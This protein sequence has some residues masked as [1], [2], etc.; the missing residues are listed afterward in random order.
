MHLLGA[1]RVIATDI[2]R[3]V[4]LNALHRSLH[5]ATGSIVRDILSP[6]EDHSI[7]RERLQRLLSIPTLTLDVLS[8][9]CGIEYVAPV[10]LLH[11]PIETQTDFVFSNAVLDIV[12]AEE[13]LPLLN[14]LGR[15]LSS[16]G[17][18]I[19][20]IHLEDHKGHSNAPYGFLGIPGERY[21]REMQRSR[22]NRIRRSQWKAL[23]SQTED[24]EFRFIYEWARRDKELPTQ[25][26]PSVLYED[27]EDLRISHL[28]VLGV[29]RV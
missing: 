26:D 4:S 15:C 9:E 18:M 19:H 29:K 12:P 1:Q 28:G 11:H 14:N 21:K 10:D 23:L 7:L 13:I 16:T 25:I 22:G 2:Q 27:E 5:E 6:F 3:L 24:M 17:I 8:K 20:L